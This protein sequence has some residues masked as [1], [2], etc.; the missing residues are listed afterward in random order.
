MPAFDAQAASALTKRLVANNN[1][2]DGHS[3][4]P[5]ADVPNALRRIAAVHLV[6]VKSSSSGRPT[7]RPDT[8][9]S[10]V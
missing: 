2:A 6:G 3:D 5:V 7:V 9:G 1:T 8:A 10:V 4:T